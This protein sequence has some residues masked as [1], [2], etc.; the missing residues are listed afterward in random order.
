MTNLDDEKVRKDGI[1]N[2]RD[3]AQRQLDAAAA[4][5]DG[6]RSFQPAAIAQKR[7]EL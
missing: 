7:N 5:A 1:L 4:I 2:N 3:K 6:A